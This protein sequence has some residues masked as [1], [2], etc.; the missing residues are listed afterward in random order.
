MTL[1]KAA[2]MKG[3]RI[4]GKETFASIPGLIMW[5]ETD[6]GVTLSGNNDV[7]SVADR[8]GFNNQIVCYVESRKAQLVPIGGGF[9][10][11][12]CSGTAKWSNLL[13]AASKGWNPIF[14][15]QPFG[16]FTLHSRNSQGVVYI[17][18][19]SPTGTNTM[20]FYVDAGGA[21]RYNFRNSDGIDTFVFSASNLVSLDNT[22]HAIDA[23]CYGEGNSP[24]LELFVNTSSVATLATS[25]VTGLEKAEADFRVLRT[26]NVNTV[27]QLM[28]VLVYDWTG[29]SV[30][31][32]NSFRQRVNNLRE[33]KYGSIF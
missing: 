7:V 12:Q 15:Q 30:S 23:V 17:F 8:S 9:Y 22:M 18:E 10:A 20:Y 31:Q 32:I 27:A 26:V 19:H 1:I 13:N 5:C 25:N 6:F 3:V 24:R 4:E 11:M 14:R 28:M 33:E 21:V 2:H 29:Y 16:I